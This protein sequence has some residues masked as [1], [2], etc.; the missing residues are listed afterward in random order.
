M[1]GTLQEKKI[2]RHSPGKKILRGLAEEKINLEGSCR[3][4]DFYTERVPGKDKSILKISYGPQIIN[5]RPLMGHNL[6]FGEL[7]MSLI[8][9][10]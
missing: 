6:I 1:R 10:E 2:E 4:K 9:V 7:G 3:G 8:E 5:G